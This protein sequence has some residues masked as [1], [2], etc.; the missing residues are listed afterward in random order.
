MVGLAFDG[1]RWIYQRYLYT[2]LKYLQMEGYA[3]GLQVPCRGVNF[4]SG[5]TYERSIFSERLVSFSRPHTGVT[6]IGPTG[7][8]G[9]VAVNFMEQRDS[10]EYV[11]PM[12]YHPLSQSQG[13]R[14]GFARSTPTSTCP[15]CWLN[16][17]VPSFQ[18]EEMPPLT[19][20][21]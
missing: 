9:L 2:F 7:D 16:D 12:T 10:T 13:L 3:T 5:R 21:A 11:V 6:V 15:Q 20:V 18:R 19:N 4:L 14:I 8:I 1:E 17:G